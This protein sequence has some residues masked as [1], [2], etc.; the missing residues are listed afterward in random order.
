M[1]FYKSIHLAALS[2]IMGKDLKKKKPLPSSPP[3][4]SH[5]MQ[6]WVRSQWAE[7]GLANHKSM[8]FTLNTKALQLKI[9]IGKMSKRIQKGTFCSSFFFLIRTY[10]VRRSTFRM[11]SF[12]QPYHDMFQKQ[13]IIYINTNSKMLISN[14]CSRLLMLWNKHTR[15]QVKGLTH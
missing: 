4:V 8:S 7:Q 14:V 13:R 6:L 10:I 5:C 9:Q 15:M 12:Y 1:L 2:I 11:C 3:P